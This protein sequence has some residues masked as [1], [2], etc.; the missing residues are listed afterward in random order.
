MN[1]CKAARAVSCV[2]LMSA[3]L[4]ASSLWGPASADAGA[5]A[6]SNP[7]VSFVSP[8]HCV[9]P[10]ALCTLQ[11]IVDDGVDSL[12]CMDISIVYDPTLVECM[13]VLEGRLFKQAG[14][15][16]FFTWERVPPDTVNAIDC[17]LGYQSFFRPPGELARF[18][19]KGKTP[20]ICPVS[21]TAIRLWDIDRIELS[22]VAGAPVSIV[23]CSSTGND[24]PIPAVG[25][26]RNYPNPFNP[27]TVLT[28]WLP[29]ADGRPVKSEVLLDIF[30]VSGEKVR[31]L[32][33]GA[34]VS[35]AN[36]FV[37][38]G[39]DD[40]GAVVATGV[41]IG[42]ARTERGVFKHKMIVIR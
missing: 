5:L 42:V 18:V 29:G 24:A 40:R 35:G 20:G 26:L 14:Y 36:E 27:S 33:A 38:D 21:F 6:A 8:A 34:L 39:R 17:L 9:E 16:T 32:Y 41:Y 3:A 23:V 11:V 15:P 7:T 10:G 31:A 13:N 1:N 25:A 22:P 4:A 2:L 12:S 19:F 30:S 28:L 37:W